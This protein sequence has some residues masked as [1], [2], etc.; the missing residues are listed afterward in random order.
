MSGDRDCSAQDKHEMLF[1]S[2]LSALSVKRRWW[3]ER[4]GGGLLLGRH[5][6]GDSERRAPPNPV[7][8][9]AQTNMDDDSLSDDDTLELINKALAGDRTAMDRIA[10]RLRHPI[11]MVVATIMLKKGGALRRDLRHE[12][13]DLIQDAFLV[14]WE[15]GLRKWKPGGLSLEGWARFIARRYVSDQLKGKLKRLQRDDLVED[16]SVFDVGFGDKNSTEEWIE[17]ADLFWTVIETAMLELSALDAAMLQAFLEGKTAA[18]V[19][20]QTGRSLAAV[21]RQRARLL[22]RIR[23]IAEEFKKNSGGN[24]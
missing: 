6:S 3:S 21:E 20:Q 15:R 16:D 10:V 1:S 12:I 17:N 4:W 19:V 13:E 22:E 7:R 9:A 11:H 24:S 18:E 5:L 23:K 14:L 2:D 8:S